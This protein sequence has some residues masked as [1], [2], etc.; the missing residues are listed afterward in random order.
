MKFS[1]KKELTSLSFFSGCLGLDLGLENAGIH[2]LLAC[3]YDKHCRNT[4]KLNRPDIQVIDDINLYEADDIRKLIGFTKKQRPTLIVGGPPCQA[5][6]T[7]GNRLS[8][9][10]PRGNV[11]LKYIELINDLQPDFAVIENVRGLLSAPL[12]HRPHEQR[13]KGFPP[14]TNE[15]KPGGALYY[16]ISLLEKYGYSV[17]FNLYNS[18]NYGVP[19]IRER[20]ILIACR[21]GN[22]LPYIQPTHS[23][24][25]EF[26]LKPWEIFKNAV[27]GLKEKDMNGVQFSE[28]R[29]KYYRLLTSGQYWKHLPLELQKEA[30]GKSFNSGGGKTGF[31]RRLDWNKPS[32]T[33]VTHPAMPATD[34]AHPEKDR[35]LSVQEYKRIQQF[36]DSWELSG[37]IID[38]YKQI[39]NAVPVGLGEA[40]GK[41]IVNRIN[42][43]DWN[44]KD[45]LNFPYSRYKKTDDKNWI[46]QFLE[47]EEKENQ[48]K[49]DF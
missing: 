4:I 28:N 49:L 5:F 1:N 15:E 30:M 31:F 12:L 13:G 34:L 7:A 48:F 38:Q 32:P 35:P 14:L 25:P 23:N 20:V 42:K 10:D 43:S 21:D 16:V 29:L 24:Q 37:K 33:L 3:D 18:A 9:K 26:N 2:Q 11:F 6:S 44:D 27:K 45:F 36:P 22:K 46:S 47:N 8:F 40:V 41:T 19:Q 17:S 39:G